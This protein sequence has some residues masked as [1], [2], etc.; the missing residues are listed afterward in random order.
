MWKSQSMIVSAKSWVAWLFPI[1]VI[2]AAEDPN[3]ENHPHNGESL[4]A[5]FFHSSLSSGPVHHDPSSQS[6]VS[7]ADRET[8]LKDKVLGASRRGT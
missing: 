8:H 2:S 1:L 4:C 5:V 3:P 7:Q 6:S